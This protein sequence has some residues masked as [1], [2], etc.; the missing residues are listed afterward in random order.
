MTPQERFTTNLR[1]QRER[2]KVSLDELAASTLVKRELLEALEQNDLSAW[3][4]G[5]YARAW[6]RAYAAAV[7]LDPDATVDEFCRLFPAGD[8]RTASTIQE[9]AAIV[10]SPSEYRDEFS[11]PARRE[12]DA[13]N[14]TKPGWQETLSDAGRQIKSRITGLKPSSSLKSRRT[15]RTSGS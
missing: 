3:P 15:P 6:V 11:H 1:R 2:C 5:L 8:R 4:R 7:D 9:M 10:S 13:V 12:T 14:K